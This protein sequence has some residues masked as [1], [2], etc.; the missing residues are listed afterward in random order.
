MVVDTSPNDQ[1]KNLIAQSLYGVLLE[2]PGISFCFV[3]SGHFQ[4]G[5]QSR[6]FKNLLELVSNQHGPAASVNLFLDT[7]R[8]AI[9]QG[10]MSGEISDWFPER[11]VTFYIVPVRDAYDT[12]ARGWLCVFE[13]PVNAADD[14]RSQQVTERISGLTP[15]EHQVL[16]HVVDGKPNKVTARVLDISLRTVEKHRA[17]LMKKLGVQN[18]AELVRFV[19]ANESALQRENT[20]YPRSG[21]EA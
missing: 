2:S 7:I 14:A 3:S 15:R 5:V 21:E 16:G 9:Q 12:E 1:T 20:G 13:E 18:T 11:V 8:P 4:I 6:G 10:R 19:V 17:N